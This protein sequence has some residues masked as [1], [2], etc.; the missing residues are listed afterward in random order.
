MLNESF[1][2]LSQL[3]L[4]YWIQWNTMLKQMKWTGLFVK[5]LIVTER[6]YEKNCNIKSQ[7]LKSSAL[8]SIS[9]YLWNDII[10]KMY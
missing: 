1:T 7:K 10:N 2:K 4:F 8:N 6:A 5:Y 9:L 3:C